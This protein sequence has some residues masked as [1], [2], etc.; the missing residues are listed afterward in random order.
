[1]LQQLMLKQQG[2][3][4]TRGGVQKIQKRVMGII[5]KSRAAGLRRKNS[6]GSKGVYPLSNR[7]RKRQVGKGQFLPEW[8]SGKQETG[9][10]SPYTFGFAIFNAPRSQ[11]RRGKTRETQEV[12]I[13]LSQRKRHG[14]AHFIT[15]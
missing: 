5:K 8:M 14:R 3:L 11:E 13:Y 9:E 7:V 4:P 2:R 12:V 10:G 15:P 6:R 1:M